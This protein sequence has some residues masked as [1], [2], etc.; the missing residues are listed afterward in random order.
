MDD[1]VPTDQGSGW[2]DKLSIPL[3]QL[4]SSFTSST[5]SSQGSLGSVEGSSV[6]GQHASR[7]VVRT[8]F[9]RRS[10]DEVEEIDTQ[11][12]LDDSSASSWSQAD[13]KSFYHDLMRTPLPVPPLHLLATELSIG[14]PAKIHSANSTHDSEPILQLLQAFDETPN[15][16][17]ANMILSEYER[18]LDIIHEH[19][20]RSLPA[21]PTRPSSLPLANMDP[22]WLTTTSS[23][24]TLVHI[25][26]SSQV[27]ASSLPPAMKRHWIQVLAEAQ[28]S[29][30][31]PKLFQTMLDQWMPASELGE[32]Q[33]ANWKS[34]LRNVAIEFYRIERLSFQARPNR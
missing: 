30:L 24:S 34:L 17:M 31:T 8:A 16:T 28:V 32:D 3:G 12:A 26:H 18:R 9:V 4:L 11:F 10:Y 27:S 6:S 19:T 33:S 25:S 7:V 1:V 29:C 20:R 14:Q 13:V 22:V 23:P 5:G 15:S 2:S 21:E